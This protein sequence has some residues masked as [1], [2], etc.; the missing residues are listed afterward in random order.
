MRILL[1]SVLIFMLQGCGTRTIYVPHGRAVRLRQTVKGVKV[2]IK[3]SEGK[4][5]KGVFDLPEG[6]F[7][8]PVDID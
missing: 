8:K 4:P 2:W 3:D 7:C 6:W 5:V 1:L